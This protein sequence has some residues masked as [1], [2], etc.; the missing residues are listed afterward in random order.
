ML[1]PTETELQQMY[2]KQILQKLSDA[3]RLSYWEYECMDDT[4]RQQY[5]NYVTQLHEI[6]STRENILSGKQN[7]YCRQLMGKHK[8]TK[9]QLKQSQYW[10][11]VL[12]V[13]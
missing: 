6:L 10:Q 4:D 1:L 8:L 7:R 2:T 12:N 5:D 13:V 11:D 3:R 9:E